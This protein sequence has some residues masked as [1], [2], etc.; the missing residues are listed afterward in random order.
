MLSKHYESVYLPLLT[1]EDRDQGTGRCLPRRTVV[2]APAP[3]YP[4]GWSAQLLTFCLDPKEIASVPG[5]SASEMPL[6]G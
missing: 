1:Q 6:G 2:T 3:A 4:G 5:T